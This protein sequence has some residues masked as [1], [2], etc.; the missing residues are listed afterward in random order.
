MYN[1]NNLPKQVQKKILTET[2]YELSFIKI[3]QKSSL[4]SSQKI[5]D[6]TTSVTTS[7]TTFG[8][9]TEVL[10]A[11]VEAIMHKPAIR[12]QNVYIIN[13]NPINNSWRTRS[14]KIN[15]DGI[16]FLE[17]NDQYVLVNKE[18]LYEEKLKADNINFIK[19][20]SIIVSVI[21]PVPGG[22]NQLFSKINEPIDILFSNELG[23]TCFILQNPLN[24]DKVIQQIKTFI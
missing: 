16:L 13:D 6:K 21:Q 12:T 19:K 8:S 14:N 17:N 9:L 4:Q 3:N 18:A 7:G 22:L 2:D 20:E 5:L 23:D 1:F 10:N 15:I 24:N 11:K